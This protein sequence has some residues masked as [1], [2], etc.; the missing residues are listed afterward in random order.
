VFYLS[1]L[2]A[3]DFEIDFSMFFQIMT[4][5][6]LNKTDY[7]EL[8]KFT[9]FFLVKAAQ[10]IVQSRLGE[11]K[12]TKS[13]PAQSG[14]DWVKL[15]NENLFGK[16]NSVICK[17][18]F[19]LSV[20][21]IPEVTVNTKQCLEGTQSLLIDSPH[22]PFCV[23]ISLRTADG[24]TVPLETWCISFDDSTTDSSQRIR[25]NIYNRMS[26]VLRSLLA[27]TRATP[28]YQLS[29]KQSADKYIICYKMYSGEPMVSHLGDDYSKR[30]IGSVVTPIGRFALNVAYRTRLTMSTIPTEDGITSAMTQFE[31]D[32]NYNHFPIIK[33]SNQI[34]E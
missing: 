17:F 29:R 1:L 21:D 8:K 16:S 28:T 10:I 9:T 14:G 32:M 11:R 30:T 34:D 4:E 27:C 31:K 23:E 6:Q 18:Q 20:K 5:N 13:K 3:F 15:N 26:I 25:W 24:D 22:I 33:S 19:Y 12:S 2:F 7:D